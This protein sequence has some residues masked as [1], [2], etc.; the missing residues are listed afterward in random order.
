MLAAIGRKLAKVAT[1]VEHGGYKRILSTRLSRAAGSLEAPDATSFT[2][3]CMASPE[4][5]ANGLRA[6][7]ARNGVMAG[8]GID[9]VA[10]SIRVH[11]RARLARRA[12]G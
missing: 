12:P 2:S 9:P 7:P 11:T 4:Q 6:R 3:R 1:A 5:S 8:A 10:V